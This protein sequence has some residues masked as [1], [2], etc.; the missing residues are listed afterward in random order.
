MYFS[1]SLQIKSLDPDSY[2]WPTLLKN[3]IA[4]FVE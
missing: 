4:D 2:C 1:H 3:P